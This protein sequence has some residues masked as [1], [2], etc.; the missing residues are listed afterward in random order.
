MDMM[1]TIADGSGSSGSGSLWRRDFLL[2]LLGYFF[3]FLS[4]ALFY[5][6]PLRLESFGASKARVGLIMGL[7]S[8]VAIGV[9]PFFGRLIDRRGGRRISLIGLAFFMAVVPCFH[10]V[11]DAGWL[12][13]LLRALSGLAWGVTMTASMA[14]CSDL[15]PGGRLARSI[16]VIGVAGIIAS[17]AGPA[18]AEELVRRFGFGALYNARLL[19]LVLSLAC[20]LLTRTIEPAPADP[21]KMTRDPLRGYAVGAL[22]VAAAMPGFHGA[23][24]GAIGN[25]MAL[26]AKAEGLGRIGPFFAVFSA[27]AILTRVFAGELSDRY[28]RKKVI[29]P[30]AALIGIN[31]FLISQVRSTPMFMVN[32]FLAGFGQGVIFPALSTYIID[33]VGLDHKGFGLSLYLA[34]F[35]IG[36]GLGSPFF[37][38][39]ADR[40]GYRGMYVVA[41][42]LLLLSTAVFGLKAPRARKAEG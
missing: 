39:V 20:L 5:V 12:P 27:A 41:G 21:G 15:A 33:I 8:I 6:F 30:G 32:A 11:H 29:L 36:M 19:F 7:H 17:A 40:A 4:V 9:R 16:G 28:G 37:G 31:L 26:F 22:L 35:D 1:K 18:L 14:V 10:L 34:L 38:W 25:F 3:L 24:R 13:L 42:V 23:V 2:A